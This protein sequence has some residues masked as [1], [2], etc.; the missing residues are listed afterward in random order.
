MTVE[1]K[2]EI[3]SLYL[4]QH[5]RIERFNILLK[6]NPVGKKRYTKQI[7]SAN[8]IKEK[9]EL[10]VD[11]VDGGILS[12]VLGQKYLCGKSLER[13]SNELNYSK[14]QI[15]RLHIKALERI[16]LSDITSLQKRDFFV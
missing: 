16:N 14:R 7:A 9:I 5:A 6:N 11:R 12:E 13:V 4:L 10:A 8:L 15:E 1:Q 3:L 2:K